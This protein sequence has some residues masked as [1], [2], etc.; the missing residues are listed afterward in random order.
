MVAQP[1][2]TAAVGVGLPAAGAATPDLPQA[3]R[4]RPGPGQ[5]PPPEAAEDRR[6]HHPQHAHDSADVEQPVPGAGPLPEA[7]QQAG[8]GIAP[9]RAVPGTENT[10]GL[11]AVRP[12][13]RKLIKK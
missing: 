3:H 10:W 13:R 11:G 2:P 9:R 7:G 8:A 1:V 6:C 12:E 4:L 5:H